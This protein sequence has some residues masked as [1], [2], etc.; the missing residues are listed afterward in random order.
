MALV[1]GGTVAVGGDSDESQC[2]I[3]KSLTHSERLYRSITPPPS[4]CKM[5]NRKQSRR[6]PPL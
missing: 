5:I 1:E 3:G 2:Y 4:C 6:L